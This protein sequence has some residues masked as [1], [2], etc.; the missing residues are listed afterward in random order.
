MSAESDAGVKALAAPEVGVGAGAGDGEVSATV[1]AEFKLEG[2]VAAWVIVVDGLESK[3]EL[4][5]DELEKLPPR[6]LVDRCDSVVKLDC[7]VSSSFEVELYT[8]MCIG[9]VEV[10]MGAKE[11][12][13]VTMI[14]EILMEGLKKG[15][16]ELD[17]NEVIWM[18][19]L[20]VCK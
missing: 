3:P 4:E 1:R 6:L 5:L 16:S 17:C 13:E 14:V 2:A 12:T 10:K 11:G 8:E 18:V 19:V 7:V 15:A 9:R 20:C